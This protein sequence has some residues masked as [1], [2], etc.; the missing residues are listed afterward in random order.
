MYAFNFVRFAGDFSLCHIWCNFS[1]ISVNVPLEE[2]VLGC[3]MRSVTASSNKCLRLLLL[4]EAFFAAQL[5]WLD[6]AQLYVIRWR[7]QLME[8]RLGDYPQIASQP[9]P[10][11]TTCPTGVSGCP[12]PA[13]TWRWMTCPTKCPTGSKPRWTC[14]IRVSPTSQNQGVPQS[15]PPACPQPT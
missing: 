2:V 13:K 7:K 8:W 10:G 15:E 3:F 11:W 5:S 12:Q 14:P 4:T 1:Q 6:R 9:K